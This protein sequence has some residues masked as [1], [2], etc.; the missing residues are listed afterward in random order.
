MTRVLAAGL[1]AGYS[2]F[3]PGT[4]GTLVALPLAYL[5]YFTPPLASGIAVL[6]LIFGGAHVCGAAALDSGAKDPGWIVLDEIA[7]FLV[8][9][10]WLE[11]SL[12]SYGVAFFLFRLFDIIKPPP[13]NWLDR[14]DGGG[15]S[16][17][18]DD[19]AAGVFARLALALALPGTTG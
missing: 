3:A 8:A 15:W 5:L 19:V 4:M 7:G 1:G 14:W 12:L 17:M 18:L 10:I 16:I 9:T 2:P 6:A 11:P 13:A